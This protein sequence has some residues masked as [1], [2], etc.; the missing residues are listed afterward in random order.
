MIPNVFLARF[1]KTSWSRVSNA[2]DK[3]NNIRAAYCPLSSVC[4]MSLFTLIRAVSERER[5]RERC[6]FI[7]VSYCTIDKDRN[8]CGDQSLSSK[9]SLLTGHQEKQIEIEIDEEQS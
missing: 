4:R 6:S 2:A 9:S 3:S 7:S 5:E 1:R 8:Y